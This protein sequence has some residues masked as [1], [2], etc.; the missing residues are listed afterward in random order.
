MLDRLKGYAPYLVALLLF[1]VLSFTYF[2]PVLEGKVLPQLDNSHAIGMSKELVDHEKLTGEKSMWT[3]SMFGGMPAYQ[4]RGD[5][6][7]NIFS[8]LNRYTRMGL[9]YETVAIVF[10]YLLG[11]YLLL[12]SMKVDH[13]LSVIGAIAFAFG[14]YNLII[15]IAGHITKTYA[16]ALMAPTVAG[17]LFAYN[18]N[19]R[20]GGIITTVAL[21]ME[22]AY[23][24]VQITYYLAFMVGFIIISK[25]VYAIREKA[26]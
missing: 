1:I 21:G 4:I 23:N 11:F 19:R 26:L 17:V 24:H 12:I 20:L 9:P 3:N 2:M 16:I 7:K 6:T 10:L 18:R 8:Y 5:S 22:I 25:M 15:I 14:S 13:W